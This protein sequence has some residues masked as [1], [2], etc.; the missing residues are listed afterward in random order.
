MPSQIKL[1]L[2]RIRQL[3]T[4]ADKLQ[5]DLNGDIEAM[6]AEGLVASRGDEDPD[7]AI[8]KYVQNLFDGAITSGAVVREQ[9]PCTR[10]LTH[11]AIT[12]R[13][14]Y[15]P[16]MIQLDTKDQFGLTQF[17]R[18]DPNAQ[19]TQHLAAPMEQAL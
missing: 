2:E 12:A 9:V 8:G 13:L 16:L 15:S 19:I 3:R 17:R 6:I 10:D 14:K 1:T 7:K 18:F 4:E 11:R 5:D